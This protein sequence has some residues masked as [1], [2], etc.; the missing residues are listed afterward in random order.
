MTVIALC[1]A[2]S[3]LLRV[4]VE[5]EREMASESE[6]TTFSLEELPIQPGLLTDR[7]F[8]IRKYLLVLVTIQWVNSFDLLSP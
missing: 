8:R 4:A 7:V 2:L 5:S 6:K 3:L 1:K